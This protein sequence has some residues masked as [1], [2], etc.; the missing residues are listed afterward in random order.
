MNGDESDV[1]GSVTP[2]E[3]WRN[4]LATKS[5]VTKLLKRMD[6]DKHISYERPKIQG[7]NECTDEQNKLFCFA[8]EFGYQD[9]FNELMENIYYF[10][11]KRMVAIRVLAKKHYKNTYEHVMSLIKFF[12]SKLKNQI[13]RT[14]EQW[15]R[16]LTK[17]LF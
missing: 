8:L 2:Q 15:E 12:Q 16:C 17:N 1:S 14:Q 7:M 10:A 5:L 6:V 11:P 3:S 13:E 9:M 4:V